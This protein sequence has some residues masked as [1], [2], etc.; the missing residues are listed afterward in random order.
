[1]IYVYSLGHDFRYEVQELIKVFFFG[2]DIIFIDDKNQYD[3][4][5][6]IESSLHYI[7]E[8]FNSTC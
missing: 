3:K 4:G 5:L 6:I 2:E 7:D 8:K 1:M